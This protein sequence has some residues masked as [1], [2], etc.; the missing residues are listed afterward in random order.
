MAGIRQFKATSFRG[1]EQ[2]VVP[3]R[4][5]A[6]LIGEPGAGRSDLIEGIIR[7]LD[8]DHVRSRPGLDLDFYNLDTTKPAEVELVI[9]DLDAGA[10]AGLSRHLEVWDADSE[11]FV[12]VLPSGSAFD[13]RIH[14]RV[15]RL[16][17]RLF[18]DAD[19]ITELVYLPKFSDPA[20]GVF[21]RA[22]R[23]QRELIPFYWQRGAQARPLDLAP[24]GQFRRVIDSQTVGRDFR[25]VVEEFITQVETAATAFSSDERVA[26]ALT[27]ALASLRDVRRFDPASPASDL[28][29]FLPD[30][31]AAS[32]LLRSL[33]AAISLQSGPRLFPAARHGATLNAALRAGMLHAMATSQPNAIV[34]VDE[35]GTEL[36]AHLARHLAAELRLRSGQFITAPRGS[37]AVTAFQPDEIVRLHWVGAARMSASGIRARTKE[38][39]IDARYYVE[40]LIPALGS[41][42]VVVVEGIGDDLALRAVADRARES[43][44]VG[45]FDGAGLALIAAPQGKGSIPKVARAA[46]QL[47]L[48]VVAVFDNDGGGSAVADADLQS[49]LR[50]ADV[51]VRLPDR[52]AIERLILTDVGDA[53]LV[54]VWSELDLALGGLALPSG[55][56]SKT[57]RDLVQALVPVLHG[58]SGVLHATYVWQLD[59]A[60]LP[61]A[62][63][64][65]LQEIRRLA[66]SRAG[67][68]LVELTWP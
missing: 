20:A 7:V 50:E 17:Y 14:Q 38:Q 39:R 46:R 5:H 54:R 36:D 3:F 32:G 65:T 33:A 19:Q 9:G 47:G 23:V 6:A 41:S 57:G 30:G 8:P 58:R 15:V 59:A 28:I 63:I 35:F 60:S 13:P 62:A 40:T 2:F 42:A 12:P 48:F 52:M 66:T 4:R 51:V 31:G 25:D 16:T 64:M 44:V 21:D 43:G 68:G 61:P 24:R 53:E 34:A 56:A 49:A 11:T 67:V 26:A 45:S 22:S 10:L 29:S 1:F 18:E 37:D 27:A 55:W